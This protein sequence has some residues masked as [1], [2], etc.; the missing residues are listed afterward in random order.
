MH[1]KSSYIQQISINVW[2]SD[3]LSWKF[4]KFLT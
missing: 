3:L 2:V 1:Y 4:R